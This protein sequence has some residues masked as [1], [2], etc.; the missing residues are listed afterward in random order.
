MEEYSQEEYYDEAE[1]PPAPPPR[2]TIRVVKRPFLPSRGGNP[3]PR[4]LSPVG[5]KAGPAPK[6]VEEE[7]EES[8]QERGKNY[9]QAEE[10]PREEGKEDRN[11]Y[12]TGAETD[13]EYNRMGGRYDT[14]RGA[15][16]RRPSVHE[17]EEEEEKSKQ[18]K[19]EDPFEDGL[20]G[21]EA[22]VEQFSSPAQGNEGSNV[23]T[24]AYRGK[25]RLTENPI[26]GTGFKNQEEIQENPS[27]PGQS[28]RV[29]QRLNEVTH[30]LQ[31]IPESEYD[32]TLN[33]ALTP[34]LNQETSLPSGFV[35][36]L[37][38]QIGRDAVLQSSESNYK[39]SRPVN[40]QQK[41]FV[42]NSPFLP[43][44]NGDRLRTVY[45][46][47]GPETIQVGGGQYRPQRGGLSW[48]DYTG[49]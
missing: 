26:Y 38:R 47:T 5:A 27:G 14:A 20:A 22:A 49:Y 41:P 31:D 43:A 7:E 42:A 30:R 23:Q 11:G 45:Y 13:G 46:R 9:Y 1:D 34:T 29:K 17:E 10:R 19:N 15:Q 39:V 16:I 48:Q 3:N 28:F 36:P 8:V 6:R 32:V 21:W 25:G 12:K 18:G 37:H 2:A 33:D 35:L 44:V 4:G 40:Q 24:A